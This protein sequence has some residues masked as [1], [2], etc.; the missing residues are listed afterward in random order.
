MVKSDFLKKRKIER[1]KKTEKQCRN[2]NIKYKIKS[3]LKKERKR[4]IKPL[5]NSKNKIKQ[6]KT[7]TRKHTHTQKKQK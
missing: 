6:T 7:E 4:Q 5:R 1:G 2:R 3:I